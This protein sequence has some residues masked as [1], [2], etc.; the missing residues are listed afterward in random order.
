MKR[1]TFLLEAVPPFRLDLTVWTLRRRPHNAVDRWDGTTYRRVLPLP[2]GPAEVAVTQVAPPEAPQLQVVVAGQPN[3][4]AMRV[5]VTA[6]LERL[7]GLRIDLTE[8]YQFAAHQRHLGPLAQRFRGMK[9]PRFTTVFE[10]VINAMACQQLTLTLGVHLLNRL[11]VAR[12]ASF[13]EGDETVHA[14]PRPEDLAVVSPAALR[15]FGFSRQ[16]GRAMIELAESVAEGRVDL[17]GLAALPDD[18]VIDHLRELRGV[19]RW[20][21]EYTLLRGVGRVH[22]FPGDDV[23]ARNNLQC[24]LQLR[25]PLDYEGVRRVLA[26]W[27]GYAG[28]VYFH[29]L[30][31]RLEEAGY[32]SETSF[33][34]RD[35]FVHRKPGH[36]EA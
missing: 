1:G 12:G 36:E 3:R 29:L 20:T 11:A 25:K 6:A 10:G 9:P 23:G 8:F 14:F 32:L 7:L 27:D 19:G 34:G 21:A 35:A 16:K 26:R 24:W 5:A 30:L 2:A 17:E 15:Q 28:L 33:Q 31:D 18:E 13:G 22:M 4:A